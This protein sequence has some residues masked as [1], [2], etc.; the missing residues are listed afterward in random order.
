MA[1]AAPESP[2]E[3][4]GG[5]QRANRNGAVKVGATANASKVGNLQNQSQLTTP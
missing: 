2:R 5:R 1:M 3:I 4:P